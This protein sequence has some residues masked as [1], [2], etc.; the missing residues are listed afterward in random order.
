MP[1]FAYELAEYAYNFPAKRRLLRAAAELKPDFLY[2]R[3]N[4]FTI[5][6][7][8]AARAGVQVLGLGNFAL[9]RRR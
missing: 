8:E 7:Q 1:E 6:G 4:S 2:D 9:V 3:Y 5:A